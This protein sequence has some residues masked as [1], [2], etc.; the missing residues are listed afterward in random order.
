MYIMNFPDDYRI[1]THLVECTIFF[2]FLYIFGIGENK[3]ECWVWRQ[4]KRSRNIFHKVV[5]SYLFEF[6]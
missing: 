1:S 5:K 3:L 6:S 4:T 2:F